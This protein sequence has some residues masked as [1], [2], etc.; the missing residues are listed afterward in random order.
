[1]HCRCRAQVSTILGA[2]IPAQRAE[3]AWT[4]G[5]AI[6]VAVIVVSFVGASTQPRVRY[7]W[8]EPVGHVLRGRIA[9]AA[10]Q[11]LMYWAA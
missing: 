8:A 2:V 1:M 5:V 4:E 7:S 10:G 11:T 9:R 6:W 3:Q